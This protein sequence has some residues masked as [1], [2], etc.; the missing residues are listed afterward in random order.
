MGTRGGNA[1]L[2]LLVIALLSLAALSKSQESKEK[3]KKSESNEKGKKN[4]PVFCLTPEAADQASTKSIRMKAGHLVQRFEEECPSFPNGGPF[5]GQFRTADGT[6]N[7]RFNLGSD[8]TPPK[9]L[10]PNAYDDGLDD[11]RT[12]GVTKANLPTP[13]RVST[14]VHSNHST[15]ENFSVL[16]MQWGQF[17]DH[18]ITGF[19]VSAGNCMEFSRSV[20]ATDKDGKKIVPREQ[21]NSVT[22]FVDGSMIYGSSQ[23]L[24]DKLR[25]VGKS[26]KATMRV[27]PEN[28]LPDNSE[29]NCIIQDNSK[30]HCFLAGDERVNEHPLLAGIHTLFVRVHNHVANQLREQRDPKKNELSEQCEEFTFHMARKIMVGI[31]QNIHYGDWLSIILGRSAMRRYGL[32]HDLRSEYLPTLDPRIANAFSTAAFRVGHSLIPDAFVIGGKRILLRSL[33][34]RVSFL[35]NGGFDDV[36]RAML[37]P[38]TSGNEGGAQVLDQFFTS[39]VTNHLFETSPLNPDSTAPGDGLDLMGLNIQRGRDHG[40]PSYNEYRRFCGLDPWASFNAFPGDLGPLYKGLY[41]SVDDIDLFSG[42]MS[43]ERVDDG[44]VGATLACLIGSQFHDLKY[45][46][47][48]FSTTTRTPEGF[49]FKQFMAI[50]N[51]T[52]SHVIC[53]GTSSIEMVPEMAFRATKPD[54]N[55]LVKCDELRRQFTEMV[56]NF[57]P[58]N[59]QK[60]CK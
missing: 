18:D 40:L 25:E 12:R 11:P 52:M 57:T 54:S 56:K 42:I 27:T 30:E 46:D 24:Q 9:R 2:L 17:I 21:I 38:T 37:E 6:C 14:A 45:G 29:D 31:I 34:G 41:S 36:V 32:V 28:L 44:L 51:I 15:F 55:P 16:L 13:P 59:G 10:L 19:L 43:E 47:R 35:F 50:Q 22:A 3:G 7:H 60:D 20:A 1:R 23:E 58:E 8:H 48:F 33:F 53:M 4:E 5:D 39:E 26:K 49:S